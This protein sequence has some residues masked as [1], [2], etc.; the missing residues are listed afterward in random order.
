MAAA[1]IEREVPRPGVRVLHAY[2]T[3]PDGG[4][5]LTVIWH[6]GSPQTG[7]LPEPLLAAAADRGIRLLSYA[8]PSYGGSTPQPGRTVGD[9][10]DDTVAVLD[11]AGVERAAAMGASGG[12]PHGLAGAARHP[13]RIVAAVTLA[14]PAPYTD[15]FDWYAGMVSPDGLRTSTQGRAARATYAEGAEFDERQFTAA[16]HTALETSWAWLGGDAGRGGEE[17]PDG[18]IDD[19]VA[20]VQ[21]WGVE[22]A[23]LTNPVLL[24]HG[25]EDRVIPFAHSA[26]LTDR[27]PGAELWVR[28]RDGHISVL[29][30]VPVALDWLW[31]HTDR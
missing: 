11:A 17:S 21:P 13:D 16:D 1:I 8:R 30:A 5:G 6:H 28:P 26:W 9:A 2:D 10:A 23:D 4:S 20:L 7:R 27:L 15:D 31:E 22:L 18:L 12:G 14:G 3:G 24:V 29:E 25:R 19:D